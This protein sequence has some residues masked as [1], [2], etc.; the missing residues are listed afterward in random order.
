MVKVIKKNKK[1]KINTGMVRGKSD[2]RKPNKHS[3]NLNQR[4]T[5]ESRR[6]QNVFV[7][8]RKKIHIL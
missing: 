4:M 6:T 2:K 3:K 5:D 1:P 7:R 8:G